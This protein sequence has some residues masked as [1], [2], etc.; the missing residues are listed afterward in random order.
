MKNMKRNEDSASFSHSQYRENESPNGQLIKIAHLYY[1]ENMGQREIAERMNI[2]IASVS[3]SIAKAKELNIVRISVHGGANDFP[4]LEIEME[5]TFA[6]RECILVPSF[7]SLELIYRQMAAATADL[8]GRVLKQGNTLGVSWGETM[9]AIGEALPHMSVDRVDVVPIIGAMGKIETGIYPNSI[10]RT[11]A[12]KL[13]GNAYLV[14]TPALVDS[15]EVRS[16]LMADS[17]FRQVLD[18]WSRLDM[19]I[20]GVSSLDTESSVYRGGIFSKDELARMRRDRSACA[21][22]FILFDADGKVVHTE[23]TDR[24]V[25]L[26]LE[27]LRRIPNV[28]LTAAGPAKAEPLK[29][30]LHSGICTTLITDADCARAILGHA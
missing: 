13:G 4:E 29:A 7:E 8:L 18:L 6:L 24:L 11:F 17:N 26:P 15:V 1:I 14:N 27:D 2:S 10:A 9:K 3:R 30:M 19:A 28:V 25:C 22:N 23:I 5:R 20:L 21:S 12:E 16:S